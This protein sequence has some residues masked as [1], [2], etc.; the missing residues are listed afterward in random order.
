MTQFSKILI[1]ID[2]SKYAEHAAKQGFDLA[3]TFNAT[4]G[5]VH[6]VEPVFV[7]NTN[8]DT[9]MG[10]PLEPTLSPVVEM[11]MLDAQNKAS[12]NIIDKTIAQYGEGIEVTHFK[13]YGDT[14]D[15]ILNCA[16]EFHADL[17]VIGT[18]SRSG[19]DR[20]LMGSV[21]EHV[22]RHANVP[23]LVVPFVE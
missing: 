16:K 18:H 15:G 11:E 22:V 5:L 23:V 17:I 10:M 9:T 8:V 4:V 14:A 3:R 1:G 2:N 7:P 13:D 21:A 20:L 19:F 6:I 12:D